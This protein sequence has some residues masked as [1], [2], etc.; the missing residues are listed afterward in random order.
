MHVR[1]SR[2][3]S[4]DDD[5]WPRHRTRSLHHYPSI[6]ETLKLERVGRGVDAGM[7]I[8][9]KHRSCSSPYSPRSPLARTRYVIL[10]QKSTPRLAQTFVGIPS[11]KGEPFPE[12]RRGIDHGGGIERVVNL[13]ARTLATEE[14][15]TKSKLTFVGDTSA[16]DPPIDS[17]ATIFPS[18]TPYPRSPERDTSSRAKNRLYQ[19]ADKLRE[20]ALVSKKQS[21]WM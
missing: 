16:A 14:S 6:V 5:P 19:W 9:E 15:C 17:S 2:S 3:C 8:P 10:G 4:A 12:G 20:M 21:A 11:A 7:G 13:I 18:S 1:T